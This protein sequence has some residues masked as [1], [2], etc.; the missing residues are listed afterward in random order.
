MKNVVIIGA[1]GHAKVIIDILKRLNDY[2]I[3]GIIDV[4]EKVGQE[5]MG[6]SIIGTEE[7]LPYLIHEYENL[8]GVIAIGDN[9]LRNTVRKKIQEFVPNFTFTSVVDCSA[10][11]AENVFIGKG[12]VIMPGVIVNNAASIGNFCI[13]NTKSSL[14]HDS[15]M[16]DFSSLAPGVTVG[17]DVKIGRHSAISLGA[18]IIQGVSIGEHTVIGAGAVVVSSIP[19]YTVAYGIPAKVIRSRV[20][21]AK[22]L[23]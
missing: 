7:I 9:G 1:S 15:F 3:V 13:L 17:G 10:I 4:K 11:I 22:H 14:D 20:E 18:S 12:V 8:E 21:G 23:K 2:V 19:P 6:H 5:V 16:E